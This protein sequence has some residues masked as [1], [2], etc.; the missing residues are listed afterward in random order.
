MR[1][2]GP[3]RGD[4][5]FGRGDDLTR[6]RGLLQQ[7]RLVTLLGSP[8]LG[9]TSLALRLLDDEDRPTAFCDLVP[10]TSIRS[11]IDR[12]ALALNLLDQDGPDV[13]AAPVLAA[14]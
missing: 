9:K 12:L 4:G 14:L 13:D 10:V 1:G 6:L 5:W 11:L 8:G 7:H 3:R 2:H